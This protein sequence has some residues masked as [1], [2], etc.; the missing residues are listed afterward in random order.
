MDAT[1]R[2]I[3]QQQNALLN[4]M[5]TLRVM[6]RGTLSHQEYPQ[7]RAG[8]IAQPANEVFVYQPVNSIP[9]KIGLG[10]MGF[11][12]FVMDAEVRN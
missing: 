2:E 12:K 5:R 1:T 8:S 10:A 4:Q 7:R 9:V 6:R 3:K 11:V